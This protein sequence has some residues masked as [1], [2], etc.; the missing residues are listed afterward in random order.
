MTQNAILTHFVRPL[1][2]NMSVSQDAR[3][4]EICIGDQA[5][6]TIS[7]EKH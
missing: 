2:S 7:D 5:K 4:D 1:S 6:N 3:I